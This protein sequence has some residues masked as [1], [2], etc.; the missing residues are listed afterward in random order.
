MKIKVKL[1]DPKCNITINEKGDWFDLKT[2]CNYIYQKPQAGVQYQ[3]AGNKFR[4]VEVNRALLPLG[5]AMKLPEGIEA[6][7]APRSS[8]GLKYG[9][10][11]ANSFG[12]I[13]NSYSGNI[14][15]WKLPVFALGSG[16]IPAY[17]RI[18]Q[19][20]IQLSQKA[21]FWQKLKWMFTNK[22]E[23]EYVDNL[24]SESRGGFGSTGTN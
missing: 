9:I 18:C 2:R 14:D 21:T 22:I 24:D 5:I 19:F 16:N 8:T 13:D 4:D 1:F 17:T 12:V 3:Q 6:I 7:L 20:R 23:F 11:Q 15:E 10:I